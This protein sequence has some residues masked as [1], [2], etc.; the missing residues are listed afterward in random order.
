MS[1]IICLYRFDLEFSKLSD[2]DKQFC[3]SLVGQ[4]LHRVPSN[5]LTA[6]TLLE[7]ML[8]LRNTVPELETEDEVSKRP[9]SINYNVFSITGSSISGSDLSLDISRL[10]SLDIF[11]WFAI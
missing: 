4:C 6:K 8:E 3:L 9:Q 1:L 2:G 5:R 10:V 11:K 7:K